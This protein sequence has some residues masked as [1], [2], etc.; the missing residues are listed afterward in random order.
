ML[1]SVSVRRPA[2]KP[3]TALVEPVG[4]LTSPTIVG[5]TGVPSGCA[6]SSTRWPGQVAPGIVTSASSESQG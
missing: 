6:A 4:L 1:L 3:L 5:E 2:P